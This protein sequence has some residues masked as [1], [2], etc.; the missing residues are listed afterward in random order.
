MRRLCI[1]LL[2]LRRRDNK[3]SRPPRRI[4]V[5]VG[6]GMRMRTSLRRLMLL[7]ALIAALLGVAVWRYR[8]YLRWEYRY[9]SQQEQF[10][11]DEAE[12]FERLGEPSQAPR[13]SA[14]SHAEEKLKYRP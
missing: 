14:K 10:W 13:A 9:H 12:R 8:D 2:R 6:W 5:S 1:D 7:V 11:L 4:H 3:L